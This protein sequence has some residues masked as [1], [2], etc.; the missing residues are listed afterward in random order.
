M[1]EINKDLS[2]SEKEVENFLM[3]ELIL[4]KK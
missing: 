2:L 4:K 1:R 3:L